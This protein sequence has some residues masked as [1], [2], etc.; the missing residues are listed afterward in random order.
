MLNWGLYRSLENSLKDFL[1]AEVTSDNVT[2][3]KG[4][5][6]PI[7]IG[8]KNENSWTLPCITLYFES[9]T[10][11]RGFIGSNER[12]DNELLILDI[13]ATNEG[14]RLDLAEWLKDSLNDG[15]RYYTYS[16]NS[17]NPESPTKIA[18]GLVNVN[19]LTNGRVNLGQDVNEV[20]AH[21][22][23][24]TINVWISGS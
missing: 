6:I 23:R 9:E 1:D 4:T 13:Y 20:D 16:V 14:E 18:G 19:F 7:R 5:K 10:S 22:H 11:P 24:I 15:F 8:R 3:I 12:L 21:R 2:D 17:N